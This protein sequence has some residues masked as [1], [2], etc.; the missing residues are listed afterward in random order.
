MI[1]TV[2]IAVQLCASWRIVIVV[3]NRCRVWSLERLE[4]DVWTLRT[5]ASGNMMRDIIKAWA[6][7]VDPGAAGILAQLPQRPP[8]R[9]RYGKRAATSTE[10]SRLCRERQKAAAAAA[11]AQVTPP[12]PIAQEAKPAAQVPDLIADYFWHH[13]RVRLPTEESVR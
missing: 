8:Q 5:I 1:K 12:P 4:G 10:R 9:P 6:V 11:P 13:H 2:E 3:P 7:P